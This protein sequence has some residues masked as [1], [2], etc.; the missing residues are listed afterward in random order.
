MKHVVIAPVGDPMDD[1]YV[2][3]REFPT[4]RIVLVSSMDRID[5]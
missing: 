5:D 2:G 3:V 1:L 4:E